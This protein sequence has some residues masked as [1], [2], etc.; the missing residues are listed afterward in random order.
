MVSATWMSRYFEQGDEMIHRI[1]DGKQMFLQHDTDR[2]SSGDLL[3]YKL[4]LS[5]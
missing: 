4:F 1:V 2:D 3:A 5:T